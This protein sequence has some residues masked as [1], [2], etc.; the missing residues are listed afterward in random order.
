MDPRSLLLLSALAAVSCTSILGLEDR[1]SF[2]A[3][4]E[5]APGSPDTVVT[6]V[7][8]VNEGRRALEVV[9]DRCYHTEMSAYDSAGRQTQPRWT[10]RHLEYFCLA[11]KYE[12]TLEPGD[13]AVFPVS[14]SVN[15][16]LGDSL[17]P[18]RYYFTGR[19]RLRESGIDSG[20][21]ETMTVDLTL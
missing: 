6:T 18:G 7:T 12:E 3:T 17:R 14:Y 16:I 9:R 20:E 10:S 5:L 15:Q 2:R 1:Y 8:L 13:S 19:L 4:T 11:R 21:I